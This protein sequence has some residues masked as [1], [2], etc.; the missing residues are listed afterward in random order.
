MKISFFIFILFLLGFTPQ[1]KDI[2]FNQII[3]KELRL[4]ILDFL[5]KGQGSKT[6]SLS[7]YLVLNLY[8]EDSLYYFSLRYG[9]DSDLLN[10]N[11]TSVVV[12]EPIKGK[13]IIFRNYLLE[14]F[15][16]GSRENANVVF[17]NDKP[18][19]YREYDKK[20]REHLKSLK[21]TSGEL[22][23]EDD[24]PTLTVRELYFIF[25]KKGEFRDSSYMSYN[26][27]E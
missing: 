26:C 19:M 22:F 4:L 24:I 5:N 16:V 14:R 21:E 12:C 20:Y 10:I 23:V 17:L 11:Q 6:N 25:T 3:N 13:K 18:E 9:Y 8:Q 7:D 2:Q 27:L 1:K 15:I